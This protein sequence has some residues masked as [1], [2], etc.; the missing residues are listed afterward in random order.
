M[1]NLL[2]LPGLMCDEAVWD[3]QVQTLSDIANC[4]V[5]DWGSIDSLPGMAEHALKKAPPRF[6][7]AGHSMGGRVALEIFRQAP[8]R[9][10]RIALLNTGADPRKP[11]EA[12][13][14]EVRK[15]MALVDLSRKEG[16]RAMGRVWLPPMINAARAGD[17]ALVDSILDMLERK[18]PDIFEGQ[19]R[20]LINRLDATPLLGKIRCAAMLL[21]GREDVWSPPAR[22]AE[23]AEKIPGSKLVI[24][25][26]CGHM[27]TMEQPRA[28][29]DALRNW[30]LA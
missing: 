28:V 23:M 24:V 3:F 6:A 11:G 4:S 16:M 21:S 12:G 2:L 14:E 15:R 25:P 26:D 13:E 8:D 30:L 29:A 18:T 5:P 19:Q 22:H 7:V 10:E 1:T 9:V 20:A 27:S 17:P